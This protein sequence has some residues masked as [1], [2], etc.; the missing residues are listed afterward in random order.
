[1]VQSSSK[2]MDNS[3]KRV[4]TIALT[5]VFS[6][7]VAGIFAGFVSGGVAGIAFPSFIPTAFADVPPS[8]PWTD[9]GGEGTDGGPGC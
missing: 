7:I 1:M 2:L 4:R 3:L 8:D 9:G 5:F 6:S